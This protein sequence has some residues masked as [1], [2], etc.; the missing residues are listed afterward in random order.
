[1][2]ATVLQAGDVSW[3]GAYID[4]YTKESMVTV[5]API[6]RNSK[7]WGVSTVDLSLTG[8]QTKM[9]KISEQLG[10][11]TFVLDKMGRVILWTGIGSETTPLNRV[12]VLSDFVR[13]LVDHGGKELVAEINRVKSA[14]VLQPRKKSGK[15]IRIQNDP[16]LATVSY[17]DV[18]ALGSHGWILVAAFPESKLA[19]PAENII[20]SN[21][22]WFVFLLVVTLGLAFTFVHLVI[23]KP[24]AKLSSS[25]A[26]HPLVRVEVPGTAKQTA[27][28]KSLI[29]A[30][31]MRSEL[32]EKLLKQS[33]NAEQQVRS[34]RDLLQEEILLRTQDLQI[35]KENAEAANRAKTQFLANI[36]HELRSPMHA[37]L[38]FSDLGVKK[39]EKVPLEKLGKYFNQIYES[40]NRLL[41]LLNNLLDLSKLE[42]GHMEINF[43]KVDIRSIAES[44]AIEQGSMLATKQLS[45]EVGEPM[46]SVSLQA[47]KV[48]IRQVFN[49]L[50]SNAIK[51]S[52]QGGEIEISF[53]M[54]CLIGEHRDSMLIRVSDQGEG[55][56][57]A[58]LEAIF[59]K[60][61]QSSRVHSVSEG[62]GLG[63][64]ICREIIKAHD[65]K[66]WAQ[67]RLPHGAV[68]V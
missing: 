55:V 28:I 18:K 5:S 26:E 68:L 64:A 40:G 17:A 63:L 42:S 8:L 44:C 56:P 33:R 34:D 51:F 36:S 50:L 25:L 61:V 31:N 54:F 6:F 67:N 60:Y 39:L 3:S 53:G 9:K 48:L 43:E 20:R 49:N 14:V 65:G 7:F 1:M 24:L 47:D 23:S 13:P 38:S 58:E 10:G 32:I 52:P 27:E 11:Y 46:A 2:P 29:S 37:I 15:V 30:I 45:V 16:W 4:P 22:G 66:I 12:K 21:M 59:D 41:R 57:P 35:A 62:T 19:I